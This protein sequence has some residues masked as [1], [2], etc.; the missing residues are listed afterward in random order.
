MSARAKP[1]F[2]ELD[3]ADKA[4]SALADAKGILRTAIDALSG[5]QDSAPLQRA[6]SVADGRL[7]ALHDLM[8]EWDTQS[9]KPRAMVAAAA[10]EASERVKP[11]PPM[12]LRQ[13]ESLEAM[14]ANDRARLRAQGKGKA[15]RH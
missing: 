11:V 13:I 5:D 2:N 12:T 6:L 10:R 9:R 3:F 7:D 4:D 8:D 1:A 15:A 14:C